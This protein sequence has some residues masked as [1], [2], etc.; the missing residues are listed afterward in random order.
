MYADSIL[1][2]NT[3]GKWEEEGEGELEYNGVNEL[4]QG[5]LITSMIL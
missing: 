1:K 3:D 5:T 2:P 4:V